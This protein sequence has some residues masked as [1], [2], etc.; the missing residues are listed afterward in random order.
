VS[1]IGRLLGAFGRFWWE[2]LIGENPD[3]FFG[4]LLVVGAAL[5]LRHERAA[6]LVVVPVLALGCLL[7][8][9]Y[10]GRQRA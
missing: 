10:R 5:L 8:S 6:A 3:A 1:T 7:L 9:V 4:T 2:F